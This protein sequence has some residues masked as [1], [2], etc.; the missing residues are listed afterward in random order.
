VTF[1]MGI[2]GLICAFTLQY[3]TSVID[4]P[5]NVGGKPLNSWPAFVPVMF[6]L[7]VL[8]AGVSTVFA[9]FALCGLPNHRKRAFDPSITRDRFAIMIDAPV[10]HHPT[11]HHDLFFG[12]HDELTAPSKPKLV[13]GKPAKPF[14]AK[15]AEQFLRAAGAK[16]IRA[17]YGEGWF[18]GWFS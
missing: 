1:V 18:D 12:D 6:E 2:T 10:H 17:V 4:W 5:I 9:L 14:E 13:N 11:K 15:E 8:F 3:W 7:T 16:D